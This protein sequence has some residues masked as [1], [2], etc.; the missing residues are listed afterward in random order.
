VWG[1]DAFSKVV[2]VEPSEYMNQLG[3]MLLEGEQSLTEQCLTEQSLSEQSLSEQ[4]AE[5][6]L[7]EVGSL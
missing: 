2:A 6:M 5:L 1:G 7:S 3:G 4:S